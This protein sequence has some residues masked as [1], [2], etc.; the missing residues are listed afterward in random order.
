MK[1][2]DVVIIG[3]GLSGLVSAAILSREGLSVCL[4]EQHH[5]I[6]GCL[7]SFNRDGHILDT[8]MH[9]VGSL[10]QGQIMHQY[11]KYLGVLDDLHLRKLDESGFDCFSFPDGSE[12]YHAMG[13]DRFV[14]TLSARFPD[15]RKGLESFCKVLQNIGGLISPELLSQG[16]LYNPGMEYT[17]Q[18]AVE[19]IRRHISDPVLQKV[20]CSSNGLFAGGI[21]QTS[22]YEYG[23]ITHSNIEGAYCF[24]GGTQHVADALVSKIKANGSDVLLSSKVSK[25]H[26]ESNRVEYVE[27]SDGERLYADHVIS[28]VHPVQTFSLLENNTI[29]KKAFLTRLHSLP[30]SEGLFTT[31]LLHKPDTVKFTGRNHYCFTSDDP[32]AV[33]SEYK[34]L[35]FSQ[36][37][38]CQQP[39][40]TNEYSNVTTL[41]TPVRCDMF[42][43]WYGTRLGHRGED[44]YEFK[45]EFAQ[46]VQDFVSG[47]FP[48]ICSNVEK[49]HTASP[50]TYRDY[51]STPNGSAYGIIKDCRNSVASHLPSR[52]KIANLY[53]T[54][55]NLNLHG[56]IGTTVSSALTC[57]Y[58]IGE[59]YLANKI[60]KA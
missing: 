31:Y 22:I 56:C 2:Y 45:S 25:L 23:M 9:Y 15:Q 34:G 46:T 19:I 40:L 53:I 42:G 41:L 43:K 57:S 30:N 5:V 12:Y 36:T 37:L 20:L 48:E 35:R 16:K 13:Y 38:V 50:L 39:N 52:T 60:S 47:Y 1:K 3:G 27:L 58:I 7:Q 29:I 14:D 26:L 4:L 54:G 55:Q 6:G 17:E 51:T 59:E 18:S 10:S 8:G 44:Y 28:T 24:A 32:W 11:F 21:G 49:V 33:D